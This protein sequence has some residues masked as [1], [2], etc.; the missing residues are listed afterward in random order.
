MRFTAQSDDGGLI[1]A[2]C[3]W[4]SFPV[5][6]RVL[7]R[8]PE[9]SRRR[10]FKRPLAAPDPRRRGPDFVVDPAPLSPVTSTT[11][12]RRAS[13]R[14]HAP[15]PQNLNRQRWSG[16]RPCASCLAAPRCSCLVTLRRCLPSRR[17]PASAV[18]P[19]PRQGSTGGGLARAGRRAP[20]THAAAA[21][22]RRFCAHAGRRAAAASASRRR[23]MGCGASA[24]ACNE[25]SRSACE[26]GPGKTAAT[27]L[28]LGSR[29]ERAGRPRP[30]GSWHRRWCWCQQ[31]GSRMPPAAWRALLAVDVWAQDPRP[32]RRARR[33]PTSGALAGAR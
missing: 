27:G 29:P 19:L 8:C 16:R 3:A 18:P 20:C 23:C 15:K 9:G 13:W 28:R 24:R 30:P 31:Q 1:A 2:T 12:S 33:A 10:R 14:C 21:H 4:L 5:P 22:R 17:A 25:S 6:N 32:G 11:R 7:W 26:P